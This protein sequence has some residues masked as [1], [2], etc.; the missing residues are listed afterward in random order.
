MVTCAEIVYS[1][2]VKTIYAINNNLDKLHMQ[3]KRTRAT[4]KN[5]LVSWKNH[6]KI[7]QFCFQFLVATL[8]MHSPLPLIVPSSINKNNPVLLKSGLPWDILHATSLSIN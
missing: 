1:F 4:W 8:Y 5:N 3:P 6:G 2:G 7:M